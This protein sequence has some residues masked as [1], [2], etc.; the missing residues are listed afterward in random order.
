MAPKRRKVIST[1]LA[2]KR[3][4]ERESRAEAQTLLSMAGNVLAGE[5][6]SR[7]VFVFAL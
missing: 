1:K 3:E 5:G 6:S 4:R 2:E 7:Y